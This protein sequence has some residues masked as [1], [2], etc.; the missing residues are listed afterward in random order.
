[1]SDW[2]GLSASNVGP[3]IEC[4]SRMVL[5]RARTNGIAAKRGNILHTYCRNIT[6]TPAARETCLKEIDDEKIRATAEKIDLDA[7]LDGLEVVACE[8][9]YVLNVKERSVRI[10]GDN[11]ERH[12][13][14][15][16]IARG[17]APLGKYDI[18]CT[19]DV[20][21]MA[22]GVP[23]E[24]DYKSG[25]PIG[26][27]KEHWQRK[28]CSTA[29]MIHYATASA[30]SRVAY[31][32][33]DGTIH[34]DGDEF[35]CMDVDDFCDEVVR[36]IDAIDKARA[37]VEAGKIPTVYPSDTACKYCEAQTSCP[38]WTT[39]AKAMLG[40]L[41]ALPNLETLTPEQLGKAWDLMKKSEVILKNI[42]ALGKLA[43]TDEAPLVIDEEWEVRPAWQKGRSYFNDTK[44]RGKIAALMAANGSTQ[45]EIDA[46]ILGL[47]GKGKDF[48]KYVKVKRQLKV[49][50]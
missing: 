30:I 8:R 43:A 6:I 25:Q 27:I 15:S 50:E 19:I 22:D 9:A 38:Y 42:E 46:T 48:A 39:F 16:L 40:E 35:S 11:I 1:M 12:Y 18:P 41:G 10:A 2:S 5:P 33:E 21:A 36:T 31:I 47:S 24:L 29:L 37:V 13:N 3:A 28:I 49:I 34:P 14:E 23:V 20:V 4:P 26:P 45:A 44:A 7:A 32:W 17:L